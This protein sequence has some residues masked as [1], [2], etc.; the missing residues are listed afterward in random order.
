MTCEEI[1]H[2]AGISRASAYRILTERLHKRRIAARCVPHDL[3]EE[4]KCRRL[5]TAQQLLH[6]FREEEKEFLQKVVAIDETWI[7]DFE[8]ELNS[9]SS[10]WR[11]KGSPRP[12]KFKRA[13]SNVKQITIIAYDCKGVIMTDRVPSGTTVTAAYYRQCLQKLTRKMHANRPDL[14]ENGVLILHDNTRPH[15]GKDVRELL[16]GYSL[17]VLPH[18]PY[19]PDMSPPDFDLFPKLKINMRGVRFSTLEYL[20]ASVTQRVRQLSC[21]RDL[22]GIMDLPKRW[23]A[24][25]RQQGDY[26]EGL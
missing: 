19:S 16:D 3:S 10:V 15:L 4:Q 17:E 24:V 8:P 26:T 21:S 2:S 12:K 20:S 1:A 22:T 11:G 9:Q 13:Q 14:L 7:R 5:E 23:D 18:P 6:R 25:I